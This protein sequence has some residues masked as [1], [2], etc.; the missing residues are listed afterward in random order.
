[1]LAD[2][3]TDIRDVMRAALVQAG[4]TVT[5]APNAADAIAAIRGQRFDVVIT[6][7]LMPGGGGRAVLEAI[8][9]LE[10]PPPVIVMTGRLETHIADEL[11][12][13]GADECVQKPAT[14]ETIL[15][16]VT[17]ALDKKE[18]NAEG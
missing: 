7:L 14:R 8:K 13:A 15:G 18:R 16:A 17:R 10:S 6:D 4:L 5:T 3:E 2:D 11:I 1:L 12:A 9:T